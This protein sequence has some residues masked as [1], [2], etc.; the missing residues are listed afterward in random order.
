MESAEPSIT[1][2]NVVA[3]VDL[4]TK[5]DLILVSKQLEK[6]E[7]TPEQ[8][9]GVIVRLKEPKAAF[10]IFSTGKMVCTGGKSEEAVYEAVNTMVDMLNE[11]GVG[12][13]QEP[14]ITIQ[15]M[16]AS[17]SLGVEI[18]LEVASFAL[19]NVIYEPEQFPGVIYRMRDPKVVLLLFGSGKLVVAGAKEKEDVYLAVEKVNE[20][21]EAIGSL[22]TR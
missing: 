18:N 9:P 16:V 8:F 2:Q 14:Q 4:G 10:L 3:S 1:I 5:I 11:I 20:E 17:A 6:A 12:I 13:T 7:Y 15:N 21:L 19:D 22:R